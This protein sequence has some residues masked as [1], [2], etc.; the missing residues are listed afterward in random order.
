MHKLKLFW[1]WVR[2]PEGQRILRAVGEAGRAFWFYLRR[3]DQDRQID[4]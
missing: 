1:T 2:T 3:K 4:E